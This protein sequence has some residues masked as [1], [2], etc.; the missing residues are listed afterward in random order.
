M[1]DTP[2][3][4][5]AMTDSYDCPEHLVKRL[6]SISSKLEREL[7]E[8]KRQERMAASELDGI[9]D[10]LNA[11]LDGTTKLQLQL[12][13]HKAALEKCE[14]CL[15]WFDSGLFLSGTESH[16]GAVESNFPLACH[17]DAVK[18]ALA[19]IKQLKQQ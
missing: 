17:R 19:A 1:S 6:E 13:A 14:T 9:R 5:E 8:A 4:D 12:T 16:P 2:L 15:E 11:W 7:A 10:A 18:E 3:T